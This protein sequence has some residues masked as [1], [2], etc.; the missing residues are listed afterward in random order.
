MPIGRG[1]VIRLD[2]TESDPA[3]GGGF[4]HYFQGREIGVSLIGIAPLAAHPPGQCLAA[5]QT[6]WVR[7]VEAFAYSGAAPVKPRPDYLA[8]LSRDTA[9][10]WFLQ[11]GRKANEFA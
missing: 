2:P 4:C 1:L 9:T 3:N 8:V 7:G 5:F 11:L 6:A 10:R